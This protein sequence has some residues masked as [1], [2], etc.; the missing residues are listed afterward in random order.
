MKHATG[1]WK[2]RKWVCRWDKVE[3]HG[4]EFHRHSSVFDIT[5]PDGLL[6]SDIKS[7]ADAHLIAAAPEL[8]EALKTCRDF[9]H[10]MFNDDSAEDFYENIEAYKVVVSAIAK[11][12]REKE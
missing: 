1:P 3:K 8:L 5:S 6:V 4:K 2:V 10:G 9:F 12:E 7:E 11:A